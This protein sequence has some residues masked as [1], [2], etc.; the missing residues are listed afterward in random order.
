MAAEGFEEGVKQNKTM[1][2]LQSED[3]VEFE[4]SKQEAIQSMT[5]KRQIRQR[6]TFH[7]DETPIRLDV[8]GN[9]LSK[10]IHYLKKH[11][12]DMDDTDW[13]AKFTDVDDETLCDLIWASDYLKV[14][15]LLDLTCRTLAN[16]IKGKSPH[17]I[18]NIFNIRI[19]F[20]P[21]LEEEH[22]SLCCSSQLTS[23]M[24][25]IS[26]G[27]TCADEEVELSRKVLWALDIARCQEFTAYDPKL[28]G[29]VCTRFRTY[30]MAF[31][32]YYKESSFYRGPPLHKIPSPMHESLVR[33]CVNVI[34]FKVHESD[35]GYPINVF[36]TVIAR[37]K[38]DF[39]CV[40]LFRRERDDS[41]FISSPDDMLSLMD[42]CRAL[43]PNDYVIFEI[44]LK[45]KCDGGATKELSKGIV[46]FDWVY[47]P[48]GI[49]TK[50]LCLNSRLSRVELLCVH[51]YNPVE[52]TVSINILKGPC[53]LSRV[54]A[55]TPGKFRDH[56]ILY[57]DNREAAGTE[58]VFGDGD[59]VPLTRR[60]VAV[61]L[62]EKLAL[63]LVGG[64]VLEHLAL[65]VGQ[66]DEVLVR[67]MG[68]AEVEVRVAWTAVPIRKR[69]NMFTKVGNER[70]LL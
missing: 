2:L 22:S 52:A 57:D 28:M 51:V 46:D 70:L 16:K 68:C 65:T 7:G 11:T 5:I 23:A 58:T 12:C 53:N 67:R 39:R 38:V 15:E 43:I 47:L 33:S 18:C 14:Q 69:A 35:D 25:I 49:E 21:N 37:D 26:N 20:P 9:T 3:G 42:P 64:D 31:F 1:F 61:Q 4:V 24:E 54:A 29:S 55:S 41:Q 27:K 62:D 66:S 30:N 36:G 6:N 34:S 48:T 56:M 60:V 10:V 59:S 63:F 32:D 50:T 17:E 40:Y 13:D 19:V 45:I 44:D 8:E